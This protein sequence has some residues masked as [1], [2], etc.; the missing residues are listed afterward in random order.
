MHDV[1]AAGQHEYVAEDVFDGPSR[2]P[3]QM[4]S[5]LRELLATVQNPHLRRLLATV[6]GRARRSGPATGT[7]RPPSATTRPTGTGC[8]SIA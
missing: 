5:D 7:R 2:S 4:E 1:R 6:L 8:S 3:D